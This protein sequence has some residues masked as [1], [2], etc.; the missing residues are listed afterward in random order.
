MPY[1]EIRV[2]SGFMPAEI[3]RGTLPAGWQVLGIGTFLSG[4]PFTVYSGVQQTGVGSTGNDRPD[5]I[6]VPE[7]STSRTVREDYF[8]RGLDNTS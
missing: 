1:G 5:Q 6:G 4:L 8:G 7:F 2:N 3:G